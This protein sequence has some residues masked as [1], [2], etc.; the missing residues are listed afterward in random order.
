MREMMRAGPPKSLDRRYDP[1]TP[2]KAHKLIKLHACR[3]RHPGLGMKTVRI[4]SD[5]IQD[6]IR[7]EG[8]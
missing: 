7:L 6:R 8:F 1:Q 2:V 3:C 5:R 4:F